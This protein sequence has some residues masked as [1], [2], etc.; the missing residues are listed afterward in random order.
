MMLGEAMPEKEKD[1]GEEVGIDAGDE[2]DDGLVPYA[3]DD[4][5]QSDLE[6][7]K[8]PA[9]L[10]QCVTILTEKQND[11]H[12]ILKAVQQIPEI[13]RAKPDDVAELAKHVLGTILFL[14]DA[15]TLDGYD[16][17]RHAALLAVTVVA[18]EKS[19]PFLTRE[20]YR[21]NHQ[22]ADRYEILS[23]LRE[24][25]AKLSSVDRS[26]EQP[27]PPVAGSSL[28]PIRNRTSQP[29]S[30]TEI[31]S[32]QTRRWHSMRPSAPKPVKN[33]F[34]GVA[35]L[36][37]FPLMKDFDKPVHALHLLG[38]DSH[39]LANLIATLTEVLVCSADLPN[40]IRMCETLL[41][42]ATVVRAHADVVVRRASL[43]AVW[44]VAEILTPEKLISLID[45]LDEWRSWVVGATTDD[46]DEHCRALARSVISTMAE[47]ASPFGIPAW[48]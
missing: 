10:R 9:F 38:E 7:E 25:A 6:E 8:R 4:D 29:L 23:V 19:A 37:F 18:P 30:Y 22:L 32:R 44:K 46:P 48:E 16:E 14:H 42:F 5:D 17:A 39:L 3:M 45:S 12:A 13:V 31:V 20:F 1:E 36:F 43:H 11:P 41:A 15:V 33:R 21:E 35:E 28:V 2:S 26:V 27:A 47:K 34:H 40:V 24:A